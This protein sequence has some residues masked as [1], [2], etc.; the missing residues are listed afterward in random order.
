[1]SS[2]QSA[3]SGCPDCCTQAAASAGRGDTMAHKTWS[4]SSIAA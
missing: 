1:M 4:I 3:E 2:N